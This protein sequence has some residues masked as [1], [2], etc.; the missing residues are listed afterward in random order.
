MIYDEDID[1]LQNGVEK[2]GKNQSYGIENA[3]Q[4]EPF[5][6]RNIKGSSA[7]KFLYSILLF[8]SAWDPKIHVQLI[9]GGI[10]ENSLIFVWMVLH[11]LHGRILLRIFTWYADLILMTTLD[12]I[13]SWKYFPLI[14][15]RQIASCKIGSFTPNP[16]LE[17]N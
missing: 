14:S 1:A 5:N 6:F 8:V 16:P 17:A 7:A 15:S 2:G 11:P 9:H 3:D 4:Q 13:A 10:Q 12:Q